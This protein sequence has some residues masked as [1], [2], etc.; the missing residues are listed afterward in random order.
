MIGGTGSAVVG[1]CGDGTRFTA[2]GWGPAIGDEGSGYWI[3]AEAVRAAFWALDRGVQTGLVDGIKAAWGAEDLAEVVGV[4][5][6][7]PGPDF[8]A[9]AP[10][11]M[12]VAE[13]GD[14]IA[15]KLLERAGWAL[16]DQVSTVAG[17][18]RGC[19]EVGE[20][21]RVA[22]TGSV[23]ARIEPVRRAMTERLMEM[24]GVEVMDGAVNALEGALW[25]A[26]KQGLVPRA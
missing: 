19:G 15:M 21:I 9:L 17:K 1:R 12:R 14:E 22:Y 25:R 4:A 16:A 5:N 13:T 18:M 8:A 7:R 20:V 6:A 3:G 2:G 10:V 23:L 24:G 26:R 11:V